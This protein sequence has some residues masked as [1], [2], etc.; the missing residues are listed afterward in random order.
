MKVKLP[1]RRS[2]NLR[3][4]RGAGRT[5]R[6]GGMGLPI[7]AGGGIGS[8]VLIVAILI[9]TQCV[10]GGGGG[11]FGVDDPFNQFPGAVPAATRDPDAP[12]PDADLV[13]FVS[14]VLDDVQAFWIT[15][16]DRA[17]KTYQEAELV[18]F[19]DATQSG[20][21]SATSAT[22]P[23]YCPPDMTAYLDLEF[24]RELERRFGA[25]GDFAQA[26]VIAHELA[27][28]VQ[29]VTGVSSEVRDLQ[30]RNPDDANELSV[31]LELQ[32]DC[33]AGVWGASTRDRGILEP[34][35]LEE[36]LTAAAAIGDDRIQKEA[37]GTTDPETWTHGSSDQRVEW[38]RRGF[39]TGDPDRCDTFS[40]G[41]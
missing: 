37:T 10:G 21:G 8:I 30:A 31:R 18:L 26:Y 20:C 12:D 29:N 24:F 1:G 7:G 3:D 15:E 41:I 9:L 36:G 38:F 35:D 32:A 5:A 2:G 27:H 19:T 22:G 16:F 25:P 14:F 13:D 33:L 6:A 4:Q 11:G 34:N 28:H 39:D 17:G 40:G 23:F